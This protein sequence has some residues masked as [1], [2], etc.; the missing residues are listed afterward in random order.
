MKR[1][2]AATALA[3]LM[4]CVG[5]MSSAFAA[6]SNAVAGSNFTLRGEIAMQYGQ[7]SGTLQNIAGTT[8][9]CVPW[10]PLQGAPTGNADNG[11]LHCHSLIFQPTPIGV[12]PL[13]APSSKESRVLLNIA[14]V[15]DNKLN[16]RGILDTGSSGLTLN[17]LQIFPPDMISSNG[18]VFKA[19]ENQINYNGII[20][21]KLMATRFYG[22][23]SKGGGTNRTGNLGFAQVSLGDRGEIRTALIPILFVFKDTG[24]P[25]SKNSGDAD[26]TIGVN[27]ELDSVGQDVTIQGSNLASTNTSVT[28]TVLDPFPICTVQS[29]TPCS[30]MSPLR[31][32]SYV[33]GVRAGYVLNS[34]PLNNCTTDP[35]YCSGHP[36]NYLVLGLDENLIKG[37][38]SAQLR[39]ATS[40]VEVESCNQIVQNAK[41][42]ADQKSFVWNVIFDTGAPTVRVTDPYYG[43]SLPK[44][45]I[46]PLAENQVVSVVLPA[47]TPLP[48]NLTVGTGFDSV[49]F[50]YI[51]A[52]ASGADQTTSNLGI[53]FFTRDS[54]MLD[55]DRG[56]EG[57]KPSEVS[58][59]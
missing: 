38:S 50:D 31:G 22:K 32:I 11:F 47:Q 34:F 24:K 19:G 28:G 30:L 39:C 37:F 7:S 29:T 51:D 42:N 8:E 48:Y 35:N 15:G 1:T 3:L 21:T 14:S 45:A 46:F 18:F 55:Y 26:N 52:N 53:G 36:G 40:T 4:T 13:G 33:A 58:T 2:N 10:V 41:I 17:A 59:D 43:D 16:V 44:P 5:A 6:D 23:Q 25:I 57:W 56:M 27:S 54:M 9:V 49:E 20:V 12:Y